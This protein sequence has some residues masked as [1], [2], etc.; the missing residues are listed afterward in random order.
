MNARVFGLAAVLAAPPSDAPP[1]R[2]GESVVLRITY[3]RLLA[4]RARVTVSGVRHAGRSAL[5]FVAA[6][7]SEGFFAWLFRFHVRDRTVAVW[8]PETG[9]SLRL[10]KTL[11]EGRAVRD[12]KVEFDPEGIATVA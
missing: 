5:E 8:D 1:F 12:Q 7:R 4:G 9:C 2:A 6:A 10:E 11:R 3:A